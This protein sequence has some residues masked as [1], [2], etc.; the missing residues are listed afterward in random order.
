MT[1]FTY[2]IIEVT[3][4][5]HGCLPAPMLLIGKYTS[6]PSRVIPFKEVDKNVPFE[7]VTN[8][9]RALPSGAEKKALPSVSSQFSC[10]SH[11]NYRPTFIAFVWDVI[12][13]VFF[14]HLL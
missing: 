3:R 8:R 5:P 1:Q 11:L 6:G 2:H 9:I 13:S 7:L 12:T 4:A 10:L 14:S